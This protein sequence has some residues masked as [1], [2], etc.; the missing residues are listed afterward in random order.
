MTCSAL[1]SARKILE[2]VRPR[3]NQ[4]LAELN[5]GSLRATRKSHENRLILSNWRRF[6]GYMFEPSF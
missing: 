4:P 6:G 3:Q 2:D 1:T 5:H